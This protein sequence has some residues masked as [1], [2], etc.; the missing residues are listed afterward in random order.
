MSLGENLKKIRSECDLS[1]GEVA[2]R[3][4]ISRQ[5]VSR[6]ENDKSMPDM[7]T[8]HELANVYEVT[9][10]EIMGK[11]KEAEI[12]NECQNQCNLKEEHVQMMEEN[13]EQERTIFYIIIIIVLS[14][15]SVKGI[16]MSLPGVIANSWILLRY[17]NTWNDR[18]YCWLIKCISLLGL[19]LSSYNMVVELFWKLS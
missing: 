11:K 13:D 1:Q 9:I 7:D 6:W 15:L 2:L 8:I 17:S 14:S 5:A 19:A 10:D 18:K 3:M 16:I 12:I 4:N